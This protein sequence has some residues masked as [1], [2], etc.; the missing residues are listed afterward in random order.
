MIEKVE[1]AFDAETWFGERKMLYQTDT[2]S[3]INYK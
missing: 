2:E 3:Y 1:T